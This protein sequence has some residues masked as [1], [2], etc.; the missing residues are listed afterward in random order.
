MPCSIQ[1]CTSGF[2]YDA[3]FLNIVHE[4]KPFPLYIIINV[5]FWLPGFGSWIQA[6]KYHLEYIFK[7]DLLT[8]RNVRMYV[9][10]N[11]NVRMY[12]IENVNVRMYVIEK[13]S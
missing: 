10:E 9:I 11:V 1:A 12:V 5:T 8:K 2:L 7:N 4:Y 3:H 13:D 6:A